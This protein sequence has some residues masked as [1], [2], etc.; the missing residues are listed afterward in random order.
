MREEKVFERDL[1][2]VRAEMLAEAE[3]YFIQSVLD[4]GCHWGYAC[5]AFA[6]KLASETKIVGLDYK[7][8]SVDRAARNAARYKNVSFQ[9]GD[10]RALPF[11]SR[12]FE[13]VFSAHTLEHIEEKTEAIDEMTRVARTG[14]FI[15]VPFEGAITHKYR[16]EQSRDTP[17]DHASFHTKDPM[18]WAKLFEGRGLIL[19]FL[20]FTQRNDLI[21]VWRH[22]SAI[23]PYGGRWQEGYDE[24]E[25]LRR[26][27]QGDLG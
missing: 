15:V 9:Q 21:M 22:K 26:L 24:D 1:S 5:Q 13:W 16:L 20:Q 12:S 14:L 18:E 4:V 2:V 27:K 25:L 19:W 8:E 3:N 17:D 10:V 7:Q 23:P 11:R 6:Q